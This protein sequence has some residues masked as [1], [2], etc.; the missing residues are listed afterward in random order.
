MPTSRLPLTASFQFIKSCNY[1][2]RYCYATLAEVQGRPVR[3]DDQVAL[4]AAGY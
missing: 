1:R 4:M 3:P 2:C